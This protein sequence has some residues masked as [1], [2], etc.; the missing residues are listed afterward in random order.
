MFFDWG[1]P[2]FDFPAAS[3]LTGCGLDL[4]VPE[5]GEK[6]PR[7]AEQTGNEVYPRILNEFI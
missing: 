6:T 3:E 5:W 2:M 1:N 4:N 7:C